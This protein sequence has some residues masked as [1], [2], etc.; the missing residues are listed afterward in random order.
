[1]CEPRSVGVDAP[2]ALHAIYASEM[3]W[4][5]LSLIML[6]FERVNKAQWTNAAE[7]NITGELVRR[8]KEVTQDPVSPEWVDHYEVN[9][10]QL[11]NVHGKLGNARPRMDIEF[12]RHSR[13]PRPRLGFEA[14]RLGRGAGLAAYLGADG[15]EAF[16]SGYYPTTHGEAGM[17]GYIQENNCEFWANTLTTTLQGNA[18]G[19]VN[20]GECRSLNFDGVPHGL[21]S[22]HNDQS[23]SSLLVL[24]LLLP[25]VSTNS[26]E[27][28]MEA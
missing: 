25:F 6:G 28:L 21:G 17:L 7:D 3:R 20:G 5:A 11:Q 12:E 2:L 10:Q 23:G 27:N 26:S 14:K 8:M 19:L 16:L 24:H 18:Y 9:E 22:T 4:H 15:L 13:G 1:M